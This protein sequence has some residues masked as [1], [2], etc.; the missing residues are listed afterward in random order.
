MPTADRYQQY[1]LLRRQDGSFWELGRGAM[2]ITYKAYDTNLRFPVALKVINSAYLE[3]DTA[4]QRFLR[5]ARAAAALRHPNVASVF[6]LGTVQENYFYVMEF[7][8]GETLEARV[9][10]EGPIKPD[11]ALNIALQVAR[12][13]AIAAR[14][15]LVHRDLKPTNLMLVDQEG[16]LI[17]K[18]IDFGLAKITKDTGEDSAALTLGGF[19]GTPHFASPEQVEDGD[20]D[21]RS[22]IYSLG[23]TLYFV[24]TGKSPFSGSIG[25]IMSQH[26]YKPLPIEPLRGLPECVTSLLQRMMEKDRNARPQTPQDLQ[27]EILTCLDKIRGF[28]TEGERTSAHPVTP[29]ETVDLTVASSQPLGPG[30]TVAQTYKLIEE[31]GDSLG[32]R[33]FLAE[34]LL[35]HR[36]VS[37]LVL[38]PNALDD[39][40]CLK[41]LR[42][43]VNLVRGAPH[44]LLR[45]IYSFE[46]YTDCSLVAEEH[47]S[48]ARLL[49]LLRARGALTAPELLRL[50]DL[51]APVADH[52]S[53]RGLRH[54][55]FTLSGIHFVSRRSSDEEFRS[56]LLR[57]PLTVWESL[58]LKVN[59]VDY[60][61]LRTANETMSGMATLV[62]GAASAGSEESS[63]RSLSLLAYELLGGPRA[64][65]DATGQYTPV[66]S[67]T[68]EGNAV[69]RRGLIDEYDSVVELVRQL[70]LTARASPASS[71]VSEGAA[72]P[73]SPSVGSPTPP[74]IPATPP[75]K[76]GP[77]APVW[78]LVALSSFLILLVGIGVYLMLPSAPIGDVPAL[79]VQTEPPGAAVSLDNKTPQAS[80][81]TF[82]HVPFGTHRLSVTL[83]GYES[84]KQ[85]LQVGKAM[86]P[87]I[88]L[89][90]KPV[91]EVPALSIQTE[92]PGA[93]VLLDG[94]APQAPSNT[95]THISFGTHQLSVTLDGYE[96]I[97]QDLQV[98]KGMA[99]E[100][101]LQL[102][103]ILEIPALSI[104][105]EPS[106]ASILLDD[107]P[108][109]VP[110]NIFS[111]V[112]F[113]R[114][115]LS[116]A[117]E[118]Y[119]PVKQDLQ[120]RK[121]MA[122]EIRLQLKPIVE[123][124]ALSI[125]TEPS[126]ASI[127]LDD[128]PPQVPP[129]TF[130]HVP[131][132]T[133]QLSV[134][135][136][137]YEPVKQDLQ[138][139][140]GMASEIRLQLKP[141]LEIP[142]LSI[143]TE[144]S[145]ASILLDDKP[146][147]APPNIFTHVAFGT[148]QLSVA[149]EGYEP[150]KQ[151]LQV[152]KGMASEIRLQ[153][154]PNLEIPAVSI[155]TEPSGA[156][157]LLDDKP[158]QVPPNTFTHVPFGTHQLSVALDGYEP[159]KQD[160]QVRRGMAPEIRLQLKPIV[161]IPALTIQ[162]EPSGASILL[163]D[164][165][166]QVAPNTFTHV[167]FG[168]HQLSV[169][170][171]G[172]GPIKQD[173][174][175][176]KG[177]PPEIHL[178]LKPILEIPAL[179]IQTEPSGASILLDDKPPQVAPNTFTHVPFGPH[180]LSVALEGYEPIKQDLQIRKGMAPEVR[181]QLK[182]ISEIP[183]L[184]IQT[185]PSGASILLDDKPPQVPPNIFT[186]VPFGSHQ[187]SVALDGYEP[188]KQDFQVRKGMAPDVRLQLKPILEIPALSIQTEPSGASILLDD[189]PPQVPPNTFTHVPFGQHQVSVTLDG[190][191]PI[192]QD[193]QVRKGTA[194]EVRLQLKPILEIPALTIQTEPSGASVLLDDKPPQ[195]PPNTFTHVPLG[196]H[197]VSVALDGYE[198]IKQDLQVR[199]GMEPEIQLQLKPS[200][201][202]VSE[203]FQVFLRDAQLGDTTAMMKV[204][205]LY[206]R[207]GTSDDDVT[208]FN[209]LNRAYNAPNHDPETGVY[210]A[211]CYLSGKGTTQNL[212]KAEEIIMP[213]ANQ[214]VV[215]AMTLAGRI[216][217]IKAIMKRTDAA[218]TA[219]P[220]IQKQLQAQA[221]ELD[222]EAR[223]WWERAENDDWNASAHLGK[224]YEEGWGGLEKSEEQ[225]EKRYKAG[226][227][228]GNPLSML[229]YGLMIDKKP[230]RHIE[231][232]NL[233]S[234]AAAVGLPSAIKWCKDNNVTFDVKRPDDGHQ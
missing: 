107:K 52:A 231:A 184:T 66:A 181:L 127:L 84:I 151:D 101:H 174:Q 32:G 129:N 123:V 116:V 163:D 192:K 73:P 44:P 125:L 119:E 17:V 45:E 197:Q 178:Q 220:K 228:H 162:T 75:I 149:L 54:V 134:A 112:P 5:E 90:L 81:N 78:L 65:M 35:H 157:I 173:L 131:F 46:T 142:V 216:L 20:V 146:P 104:N 148:H 98:R 193:L 110:P 22:D 33:R 159:I 3:S 102:K 223:R 100:I 195:V 11:E 155:Q 208:G 49:D 70:Q 30:V 234:R 214:N 122:P 99:P 13:L 91:Q 217:Q 18:V 58:Y 34:D 1:E 36:K 64:R 63:V 80:P 31:I 154:K 221:D 16:E 118:G 62:Q 226:V 132:G 114:H 87:E 190:Y 121:G 167:P 72:R 141:I 69:L 225:A 168:T 140:K 153:L 186:H 106:G 60:A 89:Q 38:S 169:A 185:E 203:A 94:K 77:K 219:S 143:Q 12:A 9:H 152:H 97:K 212:P 68:Q 55:E 147:Q 8:D 161:E 82:T 199:A 50:L 2:G 145:G 205:L 61:F 224:C 43:T 139:H 117:L 95:F 103:P 170:L 74:E 182:P 83:D 124:P 229:F 67:L 215:R 71:R 133:H 85:D 180:Q 175:I 201:E 126:G 210:V 48:G 26:L 137:G 59:A 25:Q 189:K 172:Y 156:S 23:A 227:D 204:G 202:T 213:L 24:L 196:Q 42:E 176:R 222:L 96:P 150:V 14:Q 113:G 7:I 128:K 57:R 15:Q 28:T 179:T 115:Q 111:H 86:V 158:P 108:P 120:V 165:T 37:L 135:L 164:K 4:R 76:S 105:T 130:T 233:I 92:P 218:G 194:P 206:L 53:K 200:H 144:P 27:K 183:A 230:G 39:I 29:S 136:E 10:R 138:V 21:I 207:R 209:W 166:P 211:D 56:E 232:E 47:V 51:L 188:I 198:P 187:V 93:T 109:K 19:V 40:S 171:D 79:T 160:L 41:T 6:N 191:E 88:R 177:M